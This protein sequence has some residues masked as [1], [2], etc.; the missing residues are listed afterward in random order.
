[1][2]KKT[3]MRFATLFT[4]LPVLAG[5]ALDAADDDDP[6]A[7]FDS[8]KADGFSPPLGQLLA[9]DRA[10]RT[11]I[12]FAEPHGDPVAMVYAEFE[13]SGPASV[14]F[15]TAFHDDPG[16]ERLDTV[17]YLYKPSGAYWGH[18]IAK[19]DDGGDGR[20]SKLAIELDEAGTYRLL[21]R[22]RGNPN[23]PALT[24]LI[25]KCRGDGCVA[26]VVQTCDDPKYGDGVCQTSLA[27]DAPDI[28]CFHTFAD[29]ADGADWFRGMEALLAEAQ[30][31]A[32][33]ALLPPSDPRFQQA[34]ELADRGWA[35][36]RDVR[37][38]GQLHDLRPAVVVLDDNDVNA[39]VM[40]FDPQATHAAFAIIVQTGLLAVDAPDDGRLGVMMHELQHAIG[41]QVIP[42]VGEAI[43][44]FY[45]A[46]SG[47]ELIASDQPDDLR[48]RAAWTAWVGFAKEVGAYPSPAFGGFPFMGSELDEILIAAGTLGDAAACAPALAAIDRVRGELRSAAKL[49]DDS[50]TP[51]PGFADRA[52]AS[53]A[54]LRTQCLPNFQGG[55]VGVI[56]AITHQTPE[57][58]AAHLPPEDLT[59]VTGKHAVDAI[60]ALALD[61]R[62][63]MRGVEQR[64]AT[65]SGRPFTALRFFSREVSADDASVPV[66]R[67]AHLDPEGGA[68]FFLGFLA[69]ERATCEADIAAQAIPYCARIDDDHHGTCHRVNHIQQLARLGAPSGAA[70]RRVRVTAAPTP[71]ANRFGLP[72]RITDLVVY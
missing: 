6:G 9:M 29:D 37:P 8:G 42:A 16:A 23:V 35:A 31:R 4:L 43:R 34:R 12:R 68:S 54:Q 18:R 47:P 67:A 15:E 56:A 22:R 17:L 13:V 45:I 10:G 69:A 48:A 27:C 60:A 7:D 70:A 33:R 36:F 1:M 30:H 53:L 3:V 51:A 20:Y 72:T 58:V 65:E 25:T 55:F 52:D 28:D 49:L 14:S 26:P 19:D 24:D 11:A 40:P 39:F 63:K 32:P 41:L 71:I 62:A 61:R 21:I 44:H 57:Q 59:L 5:C 2:T 50:I 64:F 46:P 66:L 38:V